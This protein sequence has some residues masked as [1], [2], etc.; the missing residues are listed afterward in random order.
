M[1][2]PS[3]YIRARWQIER[4]VNEIPDPHIIISIYSANDTPARVVKNEYTQGVLFL[5]FDDADENDHNDDFN[6]YQLFQPEQARQVLEFV[7]QY[8]NVDIVVH[9]NMGMSRSPAIAAGLAHFYKRSDA[10]FFKD[11]CPNRYVYR[12]ML[13][14]IYHEEPEEQSIIEVS[15]QKPQMAPKWVELEELSEEN[16]ASQEEKEAGHGR[17]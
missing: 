14:E 5:C 7:K 1:N 4:V 10:V 16:K 15:V 6:N 8:E 9:C 3:F 2:S 12:T 13:N 11:F 17:E